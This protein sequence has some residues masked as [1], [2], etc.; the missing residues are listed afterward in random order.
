MNEE[1][2]I[3]VLTIICAKNN[4]NTA[5]HSSTSQISIDIVYRIFWKSLESS[6]PILP[7]FS[8]DSYGSAGVAVIMDF[9]TPSFHKLSV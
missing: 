5:T 9:Q 8:L 2:K 7:I 1:G 3:I 4:L 6:Y